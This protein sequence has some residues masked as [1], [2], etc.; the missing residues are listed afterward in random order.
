MAKYDVWLYAVT[1]EAKDA[2]SAEIVV[3]EILDDAGI[4]DSFQIEYAELIEE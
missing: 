1:V 2:Y 4:S 3:R